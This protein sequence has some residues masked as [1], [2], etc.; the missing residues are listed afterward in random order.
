[1][2][3]LLKNGL[4]VS[5]EETRKAD[6]LLEDGKIL[7]VKSEIACD[8]ATVIDMTGKILFPGFID[9]HTHFD[10]EVANTVTADDFETGTRA[11][12]VGGTTLIIDFATQN[13]GETLKEALANWHKKAD[14]KSSCDYAF[15]MA[16][17]DWNPNVSREID[18][19][20]A[21]GVTTFKLYMTYPAMI[22]NDGEIYQVLKRLVEVGGIAGVH[23]ENAPLIDALIAEHKAKGNL[24]PSAHPTSRPDDMEAE[25][26]HRLMVIAKEAD[27]P[28]IVVH[29]TNEK[30]LNEIRTAR[31]KG[32][33]VYAETCP[34]YL[35]LD[36]SVY[37]KPGFEGAK[38]VCS[39][40][41]RKKHDQEVLWKAIVDGEVN[42]MSTDHC[43]FTTQQKA[44]GKDDFTKIP[45]GMPG[46]ETRG[47][48][49]YSEGVAKKRITLETAC[50]VLSENP[51]KLYGVYPQKGCI[52][53]GSDADITIIDPKKRKVIR[54][55]EQLQNVDYAPFEGVEL[56]GCVDQVFLRGQLVVE[57]GKLLKEKQ[58]QYIHR[59]KSNL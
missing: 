4:V 19:M 54:A 27:S 42:T 14:D 50:R 15:H 7:W 35:L 41:V 31:A 24:G 12:I 43:S 13:K 8:E 58:G 3:T 5:G 48:L 23:C 18:D 16:I 52:A 21:A 45:N 11:A 1:M 25:A 20:M 22:L 59:G 49:I 26:V 2:K 6:V 33:K 9:A 46:V 28:I 10:L 37:E 55:S 30:A 53:P 32:Q 57:D 51:A 36:D 29:L 34:Q 40:P 44:M 38:Y 39:P 47:N 17:S 56:E